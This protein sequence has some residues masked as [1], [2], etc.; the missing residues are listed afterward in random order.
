MRRRSSVTIG[1]AELVGD[2]RLMPSCAVRF[3]DGCRPS[4]C[5]R[6]RRP[7]RDGSLRAGRRSLAIRP[8]HLL[9]LLFAQGSARV[10]ATRY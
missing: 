8:W 9:E 6:W 2:D 5:A 7:S 3:T 1:F 10:A 4:W